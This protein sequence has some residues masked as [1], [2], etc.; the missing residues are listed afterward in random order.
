MTGKLDADTLGL[1]KGHRM[2][3]KQGKYYADWRD[4]SGRRLRKSFTSKRAA[5][6]HE[7]EMRERHH[8]K[9]KALGHRLPQY[10]A[11]SS[12]IGKNA[13]TVLQF[14]RQNVSSRPAAKPT[15][16]TSQ[17]RKRSKRSTSTRVED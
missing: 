15:R 11:P 6:Q 3:E 2:F 13:A 5:L 7:A 1:G 10:S 8:P 14:K 4:K 16:T 17:Q 9:R 12:N